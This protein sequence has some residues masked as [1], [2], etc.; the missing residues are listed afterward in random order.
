MFT[1]MPYCDLCTPSCTTII[2]AHKCID[3]NYNTPAE[4]YQ[5][6]I[7]EDVKHVLMRE[8]QEWNL[9]PF[10]TSEREADRT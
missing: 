5:A 8:R 7:P 9:R 6:P 10:L 3:R 4:K 2:R 1:T